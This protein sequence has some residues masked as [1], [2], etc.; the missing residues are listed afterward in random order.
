MSPIWGQ[1]ATRF[2]LDA[3]QVAQN[4][5]IRSIFRNDY[6]AMG[7]TTDQIRANQKTLNV[8]QITKYETAILAF[9]IQKKLIKNNI[10]VVTMSSRHNYHT[11]IRNTNQIHQQ[12][13]RT[14]AGKHLIARLIAVEF[15][16]LPNELQSQLSLNN[17]KRKLKLHIS[18]N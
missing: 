2:Q 3:I 4:N 17:F 16:M 14:N 11:R 18:S 12:P 7:L 1:S 8:K 15:N 10:D 6:Y 13:Y 5:A 9:K